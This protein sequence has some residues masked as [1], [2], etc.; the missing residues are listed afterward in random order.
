MA[1]TPIINDILHSAIFW[2]AWIIIPFIMEIVPA[3]GNIFLL[4]KKYFEK[5]T[6]PDINYDP[7]ISI[8]MPVYNSAD[9]L[10]ACIK[11]INDSNYPNN[12]IRVFLVNNQ[13]QDNSFD[14]YAKCQKKYPEIRMQWMNAKQGK[15]RA[16][17]MA[18]FNSEG[19]YIINIDSDGILEKSALKNLVHRF[20]TDP[21]IDCM[22]GVILTRP[23]IIEKYKRGIERLVRK[24]EFV[25]YAQ[26]FLAGRNYATETNSIYTL[27]GAFSAFRK[28]SVLKSQLYNTDTICEDTHITF[29]M[30][31]LYGA[32]VGLCEDAIFFVDPIESIDKLY[33]QRQRW[34]RGSLEVSHMF[35]SKAL[36]IR[37]MFTNASVRT[38]VYDH[39]FAFPRAIWYLAVLCLL[40][41]GYSGKIILCS[42]GV[43]FLLYIIVGYLYYFSILKYLKNFPDIREYYKKRWGS[44][45]LLLV[46]NFVIF[47]IRFAGIINSIGTDSAWKTDNIH[48]ERDKADNVIHAEFKRIEDARAR[49]ERVFNNDEE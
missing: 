49:M 25:E 45:P 12:K 38:L 1:I 34:Q 32:K 9:T 3:F 5:K 42:I 27:S 7:E 13:G 14:I 35:L 19:K 24:L 33:T 41:M 26:A 20:E 15:S 48:E 31:Y 36:K 46:F 47:F 6:I 40:F 10:E 22:T 8:I 44:I 4:L 43:I 18:L 16:L 23:D 37:N 28:S 17:N 2:A 21:D 11:S 29:Q 39:T 30:K